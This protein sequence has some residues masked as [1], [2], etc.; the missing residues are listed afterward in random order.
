MKIIRI[1]RSVFLPHKPS[2]EEHRFNQ[3]NK[4][5]WNPSPRS[6]G[7]LV[8]TALSTPA[9]LLEKF[10]IAKQIEEKTG[11]G[12]VPLLNSFYS[13]A[14]EAY[15]VAKSFG[16]SQ[17][18]C[19]WRGY[20]NPLLVGSCIASTFSIIREKEGGQ[21]LINLT[22]S[23]VHVGDLVYDTLIRYR[24]NC[25]TVEKLTVISHFR[26]IF[27][28]L[29]NFHRVSRIF[30]SRD[31]KAVVTSHTV[32]AEF[33]ILCR[34]ANARGIPVFLKDMDV[35]RVYGGKSNIYE[36]FLKVK[37]EEVERGLTDLRIIAL[38][39][40][41]F[42]DRLGGR[43]D[44][45]DLKNA[46]TGKRI[47]EKS[48]LLNSVGLEN[49]KKN[50]FVMAHAFS[51]APHV[52]GKLAFAD[53]YVWLRETLIALSK[54]TSVNVFVK[55]HPSSYMWGER[56]A[57]ETL[58]DE[59]GVTNVYVTPK[60]LNTFSIREIAD[61]V[62]TARGTAGL[63]YSGFGLPAVTCG[64]GYYSGFGI[65]MEAST[66]TDYLTLLANIDEIPRLP[67]HVSRKAR[68]LLYLTF[69]KLARSSI[70][71]G[72]HI[73]PGDDAE[74]LI[75]EHFEEMQRKLSAAGSYQDGFYATVRG[76]VNS[77]L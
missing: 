33:G 71:P 61:C 22:I 76:A 11:L 62:V 45:V 1:L 74:R 46:Y 26:L 44:Q 10:L 28:A 53:Y 14:S 27:R 7:I 5:Y 6:G 21:K 36:H 12:C 13:S 25:Y 58:L 35:F 4:R 16:F 29:Y 70:S 47:Y 40:K 64:E 23:D 55:P 17:F 42:E 24:P 66:A 2:V 20:L 73:Y 32:Y 51:D 30:D 3:E 49:T 9:S 63:E 56:G 75:P 68:V 15:Q 60:D 48:D 18:V 34:I 67:E 31:I 19:L 54:N 50:V 38:A 77:A 43:I 8:E 65:A 41:Y 57:V 39:D 37:D 69:T 59:I 52:G 72:R